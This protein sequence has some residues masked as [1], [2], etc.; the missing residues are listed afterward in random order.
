MSGFT[1]RAILAQQERNKEIIKMYNTKEF[2]MEEIGRLFYLRRQRIQQIIKQ[3][4]LD[5][6]LTEGV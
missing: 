4:R 3:A 6:D 5:N 1:R 2:T